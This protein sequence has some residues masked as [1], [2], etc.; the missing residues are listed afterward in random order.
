MDAEAKVAAP[1]TCDRLP[2]GVERL[3][4]NEQRAEHR[5]A[6][7]VPFTLARIFFL[8]FVT[9]DSASFACLTL[10][11]VPFSPLAPAALPLAGLNLSVAALVDLS[12]FSGSRSK[13]RHPGYRASPNSG[14]IG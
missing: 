14:G 9:F 3:I 8:L 11:T 5:L 4:R 12:R 1:C 6:V 10:L 13:Q 7:I 2:A